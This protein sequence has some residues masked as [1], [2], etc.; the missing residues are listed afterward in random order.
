MFRMSS[1]RS[2]ITIRKPCMYSDVSLPSFHL[3]KAP[4]K[5]GAAL[6]LSPTQSEMPVSAG[7]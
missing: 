7:N 4:D 2:V 3:G 6:N 5:A 1:T